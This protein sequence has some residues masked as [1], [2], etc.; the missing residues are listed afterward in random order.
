MPGVSPVESSPS[1]L[2][3]EQNGER[4]PVTILFADISGYTAMSEKLD[5]E[6]VTDILGPLFDQIRAI[7]E[8]YGGTV[9]KFMGDAVMALF[10]V[11]LAHEDDPERALLAAVDMH[12]IIA[13]YSQ[14]LLRQRNLSLAMRIGVHSGLVVFD[15]VGSDSKSGYTVIGDAVNTA[16]RMEQHASPGSTLVT[17]Q[18]HTSTQHAFAFVKGEKIKV[19]GKQEPLQTYQVLS[20]HTHQQ[21]SRGLTGH[22]TPFVGRNTEFNQLKQACQSAFGGS[23][24]FVAITGDAGMGKSRLIQEVSAHLQSAYPHQLLSGAATSYSRSFPYFLAQNLLKNYLQVSDNTSREEIQH[25]LHEKINQFE[26]TNREM[27]QKSLEYLLFLTTDATELRLLAPEKLKEQIFRALTDFIS[28]VSTETPVLLWLDD[29]HWA[30]RLSLEWLQSVAMALAERPDIQLLVAVTYR[31]EASSENRLEQWLTWHLSLHLQPLVKPEALS[32]LNQLL[33]HADCPPGLLKLYDLLWQRS[34]GNP[35]YLEEVLKTL[36]SNGL[37]V[38]EKSQWKLTCTLQKLPLPD[39][40][41]NMIISRFDRLDSDARSLLQIGAVIG[42]RFSYKLLQHLY[43]NK[44]DIESSLDTL[45][46]QGFLTIHNEGNGNYQIAFCQEMVQEVIYNTLLNKRKEELHKRVGNCLEELYHPNSGNQEDGIELLAHHFV[47][48]RDSLRAIKYLYLAANREA[49]VYANHEALE[50]YERILELLEDSAIDT[51]LSVDLLHEQWL[52]VDELRYLVLEKQV[53]IYGLIGEYD[54]VLALCERALAT[55]SNIFSKSRF[56]LK[57]G[58]IYEK[59][60]EFTTALEQYQIGQQIL[61]GNTLCLEMAKLWNAIGWVY[62]WTGDYAQAIA[63]CEAAL[64]ILQYVPDMQEIAYANNVMGVIYYYQHNWEQSLAYYHQSLAIQEQ[65]QDLWGKAN[66]L[67]NIGNV[68]TLTRQWE[69]ARTFY[70]QSLTL[71]EV[72]G[73]QA[74]VATSYNNLGHVY[75]EMGFYEEALEYLEKALPIQQR[76]K[77]ELGYAVSYA[78]LGLVYQKMKLWH[79]AISHF[80]D[81][82]AMMKR[83]GAEEMTPEIW[84]SL[85]EVYLD[86]NQ[87]PEARACLAESQLVLTVAPDTIQ[88]DVLAKLTQR[89]ATMSPEPGVM[90][91]IH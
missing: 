25:R 23:P 6:D 20:H 67:S 44:K 49:R 54:P 41:H 29:L 90:E 27:L 52:K 77:N 31:S 1:P 38:Q 21:R 80:Q 75:Q 10:G 45:Q 51:F 50:H 36:L 14:Q 63:A 4:R 13:A 76:L 9:D 26:L 79:K 66:T 89:V 32:L 47:Q 42:K 87:I 70:L 73:N 62:R 33:G 40:L 84:N 37:L 53:D 56:H 69:P 55:C 58:R 86:K 17:E 88:Q 83:L 78:N 60:S 24:A 15:R 34:L 3:S 35:Y 68:Y 85:A 71:R 2:S 16:A 74:G 46:G 61:Q 65:I 18:I 28:L 19:K 7:I 12:E 81:G 5:P 43:Q 64:G 59:R 91:P 8:R 30:D 82:I 39:T 72:L 11:P 48:T 22:T 57:K